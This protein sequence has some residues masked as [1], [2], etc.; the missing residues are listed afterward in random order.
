M[1]LA[2]VAKGFGTFSNH[3]FLILRKLKKIKMTAIFFFIFKTKAFFEYTFYNNLRRN[4]NWIDRV[5]TIWTF[6]K[7][8]EKK[9]TTMNFVKLTVHYSEFA[10]STNTNM[11]SASASF[12][13]Q[14]TFPNKDTQWIDDKK[15]AFNFNENG[16][17]S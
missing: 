12:F 5:M 17:I 9:I 14:F 1:T 7:M 4:P 11:S 15:N 2:T 8:M 16:I 10:F 3:F 13:N 6:S